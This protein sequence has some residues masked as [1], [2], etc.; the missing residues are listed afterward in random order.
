[1][2]QDQIG[3]SRRGL[4]KGIGSVGLAAASPRTFAASETYSAEQ[5][6]DTSPSPVT[7]IATPFAL[8]DVD[9]LDGPFL[10]A[11]TKSQGYLLSL[12]PDR[13]L[14]TFRVNAGL[15]PKAEVYGGWES[16]PTWADIHCQGHT[17]GHYLS[18]C[19]LMYGATRDERFKQRADYIVNELRD[20]QVA[21]ETGLV[22]AFPE[23][24]GLM[25]T[26]LSGKKYTGV[27]WYTLHKVYAGLRD[28]RV[29]TDNPVALE[30]LIKFCD[31]AVT[32]TAPLTEEQ[33]QKMLEVE[34]GGMNEVF[35]DAYEMA[36]DA[37]YLALAKRFCHQ[38]I[39]EP[40]SKSRDHLDGLHANT[41]IPK[42]IGFNRLYQLT[43]EKNYLA[44]SAFFWKTVVMTRSF[45]NGNH[46]D[47]EH[48]FSV[49]NF[50][51]HVFSAKASETCCEY[52][53]LK[54]TRMLFELNPSAL[55]ADFY[56]RALY[57]DILASQDPD[58]GM[59]TYFQ[60]NR[61]GYMKLYC[62]PTDSF[63]C[64]TGTGM[65]NHAK[66]NDSIYFR[67]ADSIYV[68]LFIPSVVRLRPGVSLTQTTQ[69][70]E[71]GTTKLQWKTDR[72]IEMTVYLRHPHWSHVAK[73]K[74]NG[75][76]IVES[77]QASSYI[78]LKR[79]WKNDDVIE[80]DM[81]ME[82]RAVPLPGSERIV[83]FVYGPIVLAG[84]LG[85]EGIPPHGDLNANERLYGSVLNTPFAPP[86]LRGEPATLVQQAKPAGSPLT[87]TLPASGSAD[88]VTLMPYYKIA[89]ER[90]AT[91]WKLT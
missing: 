50:S 29:Y 48:F 90:Y 63:W 84:A 76:S 85:S 69:F 82:L 26:V 24:N 41:Q 21:G 1:M 56:E 66:Y 4:L 42:V 45:V 33:F 32:A 75:K 51:E 22:S 6:P 20:C 87:F 46:G 54:L 27:P 13:M 86:M 31:W 49:A 57:N 88:S 38:A 35:A 2:A 71:A 72:P 77:T 9:L 16:A 34:H 79:V 83:A 7:R 5:P 43:G 91:Y 19:S 73:V 10:R 23:G 36:G 8:G 62:T 61:P 18:A 89:H 30:V 81:V 64:C 53:M 14:H 25:A 44:A 58:T 11:R 15:Q 12:Q 60:G 28:A 3:L 68:N 67:G 70:P 55:H 78:E 40:L 17:L 37:R 59:V 47:E 74:V 65:E 80:L 52:N 39:L